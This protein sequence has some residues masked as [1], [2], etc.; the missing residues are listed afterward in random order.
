MPGLLNGVTTV[1]H[2][3]P[4]G[5]LRIQSARITLP[6]PACVVS[7]EDWLQNAIAQLFNSPAATDEP[8][9][10]SFFNVSTHQWRSVESR[11]VRHKLAVALP[12][13]TCP[14]KLSGGAF[15]VPKD[16]DRELLIAGHRTVKSPR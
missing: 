13:D 9:G 10:P 12:S 7:L 4:A 1:V 16:L 8:S 15:A 14:V 11:M 2:V 6:D 5:A 3:D